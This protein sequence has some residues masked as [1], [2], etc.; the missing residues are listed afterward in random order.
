MEKKTQFKISQ[1]LLEI[2]VVTVG[3]LIAFQLNNWKEVRAS[4]DKEEKMLKEIKTNL[5]LDLIDLRDNFSGHRMALEHIESLQNSDP[6]FE[7]NKVG[8]KF[9][10]AFRDFIFS[11][12]TSAFETLKARGVDLISNDSLRIEILRL[13]DFDYVI[14]EKIEENYAPS[15]FTHHYQYIVLNYYDKLQNGDI[16]WI[17]SADVQ[18]RLSLVR[19]ERQYV[20]RIYNECIQKV[21]VL[22]SK[23]NKEI[24][25]EF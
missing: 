16:H 11:P 24:Q 6:T 25:N 8:G 18:N 23:I 15:Q 2:V 13:Y 12:Q 1:I 21:E 10:S 9:H 5:A 19:F 17:S 4:K 7:R 20:S 22:I 3:I 14:I